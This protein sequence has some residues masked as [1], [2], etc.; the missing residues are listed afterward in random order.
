M[1]LV[2]PI[3]IPLGLA[4]LIHCYSEFDGA[5][6]AISICD[7]VLPLWYRLPLTSET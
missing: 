7:H 3:N 2:M 5:G 4:L 6:K 1:E